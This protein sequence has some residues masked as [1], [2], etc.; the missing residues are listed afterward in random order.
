MPGI[1]STKIGHLDGQEVVTVEYDPEQTNLKNMSDALKRER[2][3][4]SLV[5][6]DEESGVDARG[7]L[8]RSEIQINSE[9]PRFIESKHSL[10][11]GHPELYRL[12]LSEDQKRILNSWSY[13]G[14]PMPDVLTDQQKRMLAEQEEESM[15]SRFLRWLRG[16]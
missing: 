7:Y 1:K 3:F 15:P 6:E 4:G 9:K 8:R 14:G 5:V 2:S 16:Q 13:F 11:S 12:D 10:R